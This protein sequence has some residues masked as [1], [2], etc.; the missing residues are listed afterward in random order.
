MNKYLFSLTI[1][2]IIIAIIIL[3]LTSFIT[4]KME[5]FAIDIFRVSTLD[6]INQSSTN[7]LLTLKFNNGPSFISNDGSYSI[8]TINNIGNCISNTTDYVKGNSSAEFN[9][10]SCFTIQ[11]NTQFNNNNFTISFFIKMVYIQ[12]NVI[13]IIASNSYEDV[14]IKMGWILCVNNKQ[15]ELRLGTG[16]S[17][18]WNTL[19]S[20]PNFINNIPE[21]RHVSFNYNRNNNLWN[22]FIDGILINQAT[23]EYISP[24]SELIDDIRIIPEVCTTI[25]VDETT[26][27][28]TDITRTVGTGTYNYRNGPI[29]N[30]KVRLWYHCNR[31][32]PYLDFGVGYKQE[33][34]SDFKYNLSGLEIPSGMRVVLIDDNNTEARWRGCGPGTERTF[35]AG[36]YPCLWSYWWNDKAT[37]ISVYDDV[38]EYEQLR[39]EI[40]RQEV[41]GQNCNDVRTGRK[42]PRRSCVNNVRE[43]Y[44]RAP[45]ANELYLIIG[46]GGNSVS[47]KNHLPRGTLIDDFKFYNAT[48]NSDEI[49]ELYLGYKAPTS[50]SSQIS[51]ANLSD[52]DPNDRKIYSSELALVPDVNTKIS[53]ISEITQIGDN[54][55]S[56]T[57]N[58]GANMY[59]LLFSQI[60]NNNKNYSPAN[61]FN[62]GSE[63][64]NDIC[65]FANNR[66]NNR[67]NY[68][69]DFMYDTTNLNLRV[70]NC[71]NFTNITI[72]GDYLY[73]NTGTPFILGRYGIKALPNFIARAPSLWTLYIFDINNR[74][75]IAYQQSTKLTKND[76]CTNNNYVYV[77]D[78]IYNENSTPIEAN[79]YLFVFQGIV[80]GSTVDPF[81][82]LAFSELLLYKK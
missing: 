77:N 32:G 67:S 4:T 1:S 63:I 74:K 30:R 55:Y 6:V 70:P 21:W 58:V 16:R 25:D 42:I 20:Y 80:G 33:L 41:I 69:E 78:I 10:L 56:Q 57:F 28:C 7:P 13:K 51:M 73:I 60:L 45:L 15:L 82:L 14:N 46:A 5:A 71:G 59:Q 31:G 18:T 52:C 34:H 54:K 72:Q 47:Q 66:A 76:Y 19:I 11:T 38:P 22:L 44:R 8:K 9:G 75:A 23:G 49:T 64:E 62:K 36:F 24:T 3:L 26:R 53:V 27:V 79:E 61:L 35:T 68:K 43:S 81:R 40:T 48:L 17:N 50:S 29:K 12:D 65:A 39:D 2:F 37:H